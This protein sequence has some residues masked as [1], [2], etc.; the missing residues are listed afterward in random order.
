MH[1]PIYDVDGCDD[2]GAPTDD[3]LHLQEAFESLFLKYKV[4]VVVA[5]HRHYYERQLPIANSSAVMDGVSNDYKVY[6]NPQAPV[7]ILTGAAGNVENLRD[8]PKGTAPWNAA[9]EYSHFG[10]STL[11]ANRTMLSWKYLASSGLSVQDEF[12]MY[13]SF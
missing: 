12:V 10:S 9:Y 2:D 7:H 4:D 6:D 1:R 8:A 5:G 13:K 11:E 3:N